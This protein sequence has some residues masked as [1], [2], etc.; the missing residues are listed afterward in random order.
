M[1][2]ALL[3][4]YLGGFIYAEADMVIDAPKNRTRVETIGEHIAVGTVINVIWPVKLV[5]KGMME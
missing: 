5:A 4:I 2:T 3:C 1:I